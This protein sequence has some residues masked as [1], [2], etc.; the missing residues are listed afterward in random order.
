MIMAGEYD[1][2]TPRPLQDSLRTHIA[3]SALV[4]IPRAYHAFTLERPELAAYLTARFAED[5]MAGRW[6][7]KKSI[8][9]AQDEPGGEI[10]T[11]SSLRPAALAYACEIVRELLQ[12][13][14]CIDR[15]SRVTV[16]DET[17]PMVLSIPFLAAYA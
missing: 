2:L 4:I 7:G 13:L 5:V 17:R 16:R 3:D 15:N 1:F 12:N 8:W 9:V 6:Y 10:T 11:L 14:T